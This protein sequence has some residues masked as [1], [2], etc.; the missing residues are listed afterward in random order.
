MAE[1]ITDYLVRMFEK[2]RSK[3]YEVAGLRDTLEIAEYFGMDKVQTRRQ[4]NKLYAQGLVTCYKNR[5]R[6]WA[7]SVRA[8]KG[9]MFALS[10]N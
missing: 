6:L 5:P 9:P 4:L 7:A 2:D 3:G 8:L 1:T 10:S